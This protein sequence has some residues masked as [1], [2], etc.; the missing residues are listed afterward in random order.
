MKKAIA[1]QASLR[2]YVMYM[3]DLHASSVA[4]TF[5]FPQIARESVEQAL[6]KKLLKKF[7]IVPESIRVDGTIPLTVFQS[8]KISP[9]DVSLV[10]EQQVLHS[11]AIPEPPQI[12]AE[13]VRIASYNFVITG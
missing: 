9:C 3:Q 7:S 12:V 11:S 1:R 6:D 4:V 10:Q 5:A 8:L 2:P 13:E